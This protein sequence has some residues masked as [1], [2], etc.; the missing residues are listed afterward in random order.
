MTQL[1]DHIETIRREAY[2][3]GY[4]A[5]MRDVLALPKPLFERVAPAAPHC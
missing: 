4:E 3:E 1:E 5:A 2:Q